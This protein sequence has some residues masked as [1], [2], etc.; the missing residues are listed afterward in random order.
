METIDL[1]DLVKEVARILRFIDSPINVNGLNG[2]YRIHCVIFKDDI[3]ETDHEPVDDEIEVNRIIKR[4]GLFGDEVIP[5]K[6]LDVR[7][8]V[9][10]LSRRSGIV[11]I[12]VVGKRYLPTVNDDDIVVDFKDP[13]RRDVV[14]VTENHPDAYSLLLKEVK[15]RIQKNIASKPSKLSNLTRII[16]YINKIEGRETRFGAAPVIPLEE[17]LSSNAD[18][19]EQ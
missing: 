2:S 4:Q 6:A 10:A 13:I 1:H 14:Y 11:E 8:K 7:G 18:Q 5:S 16:N 3:Q 17:S 12:N 19:D 15:R 9:I